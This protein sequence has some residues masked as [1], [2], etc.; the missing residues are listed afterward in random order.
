MPSRPLRLGVETSI[1]LL[2]PVLLF[3]FVIVGDICGI[4]FYP[5]IFKAKTLYL[6]WC[7]AL[8][9]TWKSR[10]LTTMP[11]T[12]DICVASM[13]GSI[14]FWTSCLCSDHHKTCKR[15]EILVSQDQRQKQQDVLQSLHY[16]SCATC[17]TLLNRWHRGRCSFPA[18]SH[19]LAAFS[20]AVLR[21]SPNPNWRW[22]R[23]GRFLSATQGGRADPS[24]FSVN[25]P[26]CQRYSK[27]QI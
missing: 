10:S 19:P 13:R 2:L 23:T 5:K 9:N 14:I 21:I 8:I 27:A 20:G 6:S 22:S 7:P 11:E 24:A 18:F 25:L 3:L 16:L 17:G 15:V 4:F 1:H 12:S 26:D